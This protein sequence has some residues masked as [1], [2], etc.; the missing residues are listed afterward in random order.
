VIVTAASQT[1]LGEPLPHDWLGWLVL[2]IGIWSG[3]SV[4]QIAVAA[5]IDEHKEMQPVK[6]RLSGY[7]LP[8]GWISW[9]GLLVYGEPRPLPVLIVLLGLL[10]MLILFREVRK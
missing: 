1:L 2:L 6:P 3:L 7:V 8:V 4:F 5:F 9:G 10:A